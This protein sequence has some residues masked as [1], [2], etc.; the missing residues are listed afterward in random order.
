MTLSVAVFDIATW[1]NQCKWQN[2]DW[3]P[4]NRRKYWN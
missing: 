2:H 3:K 1:E 4:E